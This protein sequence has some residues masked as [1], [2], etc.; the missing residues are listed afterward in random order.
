[1][2]TTVRPGSRPYLPNRYGNDS[3]D[4]IELDFAHGCVRRQGT[5]C[6][7][8]HQTFQVLLC[9]IE[10]PGETVSKEILTET[11][12]PDTA[13]TENALTQCIAEIRKA[14]GDDSRNPRYIR[15]IS[16]AGYCFIAP[17][18]ETGPAES[19]LERA[20]QP[21]PYA[22]TAVSQE[23][24]TS[25]ADPTTI[26][27][28]RSAEIFEPPSIPT[29][30]QRLQAMPSFVR[31]A[32]SLPVICC[33]LLIAFWGIKRH[34]RA[35]AAEATTGPLNKQNLAIM[36]FENDS[37]STDLDWLCQ[38]LTD[39]MITDMSRS[40]LLHVLSRQQLSTLLP[41]AVSKH[42]EPVSFDQALH[43]AHIAHAASLLMGNVS[44]INDNIRI[45]VQLHD[46]ATGQI[47][48]ADHIVFPRNANLLSQ[49][50]ILASRLANTLEGSATVRPSLSAITTDNIEAYRYYSLGVEKAQQLENSEA[51]ELL[52]QATQ[53]DP[54]FAMAWARIG[55][56]YA[57]SDFV[58]EKG[59]FY[60][61]K[62]L[63]LSKRLTNKDLLYVHAWYAISR[64]DF[65]QAIATFREIIRLY[66]QESEAYWRLAKLLRGSEHC[67]EALNVIHQGLELA[68][69]DPAL[70]N[71]EG[72]VL[73]GLRRYP[74]AIDAYRQYVNAAPGSPNGHDSL[75]MAWQQ[76][77]N[78]DAA[79]AEYNQALSLDP[80]FEPSIIHLGDVY[81]QTG[82]Y[83]NAVYQ[84][85]RYVAVAQTA[86]AR[87]LG[88]SDLATVYLAMNDLPKAE[89]AAAY[90]L[91][92]NPHAVWSSLE[93]A[94]RTGNTKAAP[95]YEQQLFAYIPTQ[96]RGM[97][98]DQRTR[99]YYRGSLALAHNHSDEALAAFRIA[100][101]HLP[102]TSGID[103]YEDCLANAELRLGRYHESIAEYNRILD[104][105]PNY[106]LVHYHLAEAYRRL[107]DERHE[108]SEYRAFLQSW[109]AADNLPAVQE[110]RL[111]L[112]SVGS[113]TASR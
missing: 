23:V 47:T 31:R 46:A 49:I 25:L 62:A 6:F 73:L 2:G 4:E 101:T 66:P 72:L 77:G 88:Y 20:Q 18:I 41:V 15:T 56:T 70:Y 90:E 9:L 74:E 103:L 44:A 8:R 93:L 5:E 67:E 28:L 95:L 91:R 39:M 112:S 104:L 14:L 48:F 65:P 69:N 43:I 75:G 76:S 86:N 17:A 102:P 57:L 38:G 50:D 113:H 21:V 92:D 1:M 89:H 64:S 82:Q 55:Y 35:I 63:H 58:P 84:Y 109:Q 80:T 13:V 83:R 94:L 98:G 3:N 52:K 107:G 33:L 61:E 42:G 106:P 71:I 16:R 51:I 59:R 11:I 53:F 29:Q 37:G 60:L 100:L 34:E 105:D 85:Q 68:P 99:Y 78:Y 45:D 19:A 54:Q 81:Y 110:T 7:L 26:A 97:Q 36:Y 22:E 10:R 24:A 79:T 111:Q 30:H 32:W 40:G 27:A 87:A 108:Q 12:W 96:E